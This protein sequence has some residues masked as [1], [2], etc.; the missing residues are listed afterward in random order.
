MRRL[1]FILF[2][3]VFVKSHC[4]TPVY[5]LT[6]TSEIY[7]VTLSNCTASLIIKNQ[8]GGVDI[9]LT[10][11]RRLWV[12][13][14]TQIHEVDT[15]TGAY[16]NLSASIPSISAPP[17]MVALNDSVLMVE[18]NAKLFKFN[19]T[20]ALN[21]PM[22]STLVGNLGYLSNGDLTWYDNDLYMSS[23]NTLVRIKLNNN[24]SSIISVTPLRPVESNWGISNWG[25]GSVPFP[26]EP[27][28]FIGTD[29]RSIIKICHID[30]SSGMLCP[31][32]VP[33]AIYGLATSAASK[34]YAEC[35]RWQ[36]YFRT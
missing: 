19:T 36:L 31:N 30:G 16:S 9:A 12:V 11:S 22:T 7:K 26:G 18:Y 15:V 6:A 13:I 27:N 5:V 29:D 21:A 35:V 8:F 3:A 23:S 24:F 32:I 10:P 34:S 33:D 1:L 17:G 4:Q 20:G 25:L 28:A 2:V 14:G